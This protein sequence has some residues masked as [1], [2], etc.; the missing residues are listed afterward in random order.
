MPCIICWPGGSR[1]AVCFFCLVRWLL[2]PCLFF[3]LIRW[4][5][6]SCNTFFGPVDLGALFCFG[7]VRWLL[8][9]S[10]FLLVRWLL[11]HCF[12]CL[13]GGVRWLL[14]HPPPNKNTLPKIQGSANWQIAISHAVRDGKLPSRTPCEM[15]ICR[16]APV[17]P[18]S[19]TP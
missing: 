9:P 14:M 17:A 2:M 11:V 3:C 12:F 18:G 10:F 4:L 15:A 8:I 19:P 13:V 6:L 16:L 1:C 5:V 7:F